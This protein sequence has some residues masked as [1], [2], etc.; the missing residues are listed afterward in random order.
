MF[1]SFLQPSNIIKLYMKYW[2]ELEFMCFLPETAWRVNSKIQVVVMVVA[3]L[4]TTSTPPSTPRKTLRRSKGCPFLRSG[5]ASG[6][7]T[8]S[9][10]A[11]GTWENK[12]LEKSPT[13]MSERTTW[14]CDISISWPVF[15]CSFAWNTFDDSKSPSHWNYHIYS[16]ITHEPLSQKSA[17][18]LHPHPPVKFS[19]YRVFWWSEPGKLGM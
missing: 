6:T 12:T 15:K 4:F 8:S 5:K 17:R 1:K 13:F 16:Y 19:R 11:R 9:L 18:A 14:R 7:A 3:V 2:F 10:C